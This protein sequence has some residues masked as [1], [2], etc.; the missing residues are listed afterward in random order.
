MRQDV[1]RVGND[2]NSVIHQELVK[3][4]ASRNSPV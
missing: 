1:I 3:R 4:K 2:F